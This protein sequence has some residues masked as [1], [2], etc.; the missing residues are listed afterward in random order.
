VYVIAVPFKEIVRLHVDNHV[1]IARWS[2]IA[3]FLTL[4][5]QAQACPVINASG[6]LHRQLFGSLYQTRP[7]TGR[8]GMGNHHPLPT[9][10]GTRG[11][12]GEKSLTPFYLTQAPAGAARGGAG[13]GSRTLA[14]TVDTG[15]QLLE[16]QQLLGAKHR[17]FKRHLHIVP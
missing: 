11:A 16:L 10:M 15:F 12:Q 13:A 17:L 2:T 14:Q 4:I 3:P 7:A 6:D 1:E 5:G 8:T 9:A